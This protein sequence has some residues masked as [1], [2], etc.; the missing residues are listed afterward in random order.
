VVAR[1]GVEPPTFRFLEGFAGP[2]RSITGRL[3]GPTA[4]LAPF[5]IQDRPHASTAVVSKALARSANDKSSG[6]WVSTG[7]LACHRWH[8]PN[9][10]AT[11]TGAHVF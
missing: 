7:G 9:L 3:T 6:R 10:M 11:I 8:G 5:G 1:G 2:G 4:A